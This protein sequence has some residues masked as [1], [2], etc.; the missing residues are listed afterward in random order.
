[1]VPTTFSDTVQEALA[2]SDPPESVKLPLPATAVLVPPQVEVKPF[3][4]ATTTPDGNVSVNAKPVSAVPALGLLMVKES[5]DVPPTTIADGVKDLLSAGAVGAFTVRVAVAA[6]PA[7]ASLDATVEV[8]LTLVPAVVPSTFSDT[9]Q[10]PLAATEPPESVKLP[11][12]ATAVLVPPQV[13][14]KAFG[15]ATTTP[16]GNVSVNATPVRP[17]P[18]LGLLMVKE[19]ADVPP[20][21]MVDGVKDLLSVGAVAAFTERVALAVLPVPPSELTC[22]ELFFAPVVV[23]VT[24]TE[25]S[26]LPRPP[27]N[28]SVSEKLMLEL[29]VAAVAVGTFALLQDALRLFGVATTRPGGRVSVNV[30]LKADEVSLFLTVMIRV[31]VPPT[32]MDAGTKNLEIVGIPFCAKAGLAVNEAAA[33]AATSDAS[34]AARRGVRSRRYLPHPEA[35]AAR[36]GSDATRCH[37]HPAMEYPPDGPDQH[38]APR[39]PLRS[40]GTC[41][42]TW[43]LDRPSRFAR[44]GCLPGFAADWPRAQ[45]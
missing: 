45:P 34:T 11:L 39:M 10:D 6:A 25:T 8:V 17:N 20:T 19:S 22:T 12:P 7:G 15:V 16:D 36:A 18:A 30:A 24:L 31:V 35:A 40:A 27:P 1:V 43:A 3:G 32:A 9:V 4:V 13:E 14:L 29:P 28:I 37:I 41:Y 38:G 5:A 42:R 2:A 26:Q 33:S 23:A 44:S 21:T